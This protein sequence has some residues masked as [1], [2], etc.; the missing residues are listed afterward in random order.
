MEADNGG[1]RR[2]LL[3]ARGETRPYDMRPYYVVGAAAGRATATATAAEEQLRQQ[4]AAACAGWAAG[5]AADA[6]AAVAASAAARQGAAAAASAAA[7]EHRLRLRTRLDSAPFTLGP[8]SG[9]GKPRDAIGAFGIMAI[10]FF[11]VSGGPFGAEE[12]ISSAGPLPGLVG[13][14]LFAVLWA[15]PMV[16]VTAELSSAYPDD[17]GYS[18]WVAEAFGSFWGFQEAYWSWISGVIDTAIYPVLAWDMAKAVVGLPDSFAVAWGCKVV[19]ALLFV[20]P[21]LCGSQGFA[22]WMSALTAFVLLPFVVCTALLVLYPGV[23]P[24]AQQRDFGRLLEVRT[25]AD[26][27]AWASL[28]SVLYW[29]FSGFDAASTCAG[30]VRDPGRSYPRGLLAAL[31]LVTV[32]YVLP[33]TA[34]AAV[35]VP[36]WA[37]WKEGDFSLIAQ[38]QVGQWMCS[39]VIVSSAA[40]NTGMYTAEVFED[41]WQL[42]GM[43]RKGLMP[44]V[45]ARRHGGGGGGEGGVPLVAIAFALLIICSLLALEFDAIVCITNLFSCLA[46]MLELVAFLKLRIVDPNL[47]RPFRIPVSSPSVLA[48]ML[49]PSLLIGL[50]VCASSLFESSLSVAIN[51]VALVVGVALYHGM[52]RNGQIVYTALAAP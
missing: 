7:G 20:L 3:E 36:H 38:Q 2:S 32:T 17:G 34:F 48:A 41:S 6:A 45:F 21:N 35:D 39:W 5:S 25:D 26:W 13:V 51:A 33:L 42:C 29:N 52:F 14:A 43:A 28:V 1:E 16:L 50:F 4:D 40:A 46:A 27:G 11:S 15:L 37:S 31:A 24:A 44:K 23:S 8:A 12:V 22:R 19:M 9:H 47:V 18:I 30:E 49:M 10:T